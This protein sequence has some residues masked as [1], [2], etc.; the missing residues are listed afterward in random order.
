MI[1][2]P[3]QPFASANIVQEWRFEATHH[4][5]DPF[6][7]VDVDMLIENRHGE[8]WLVPA[9]WAGG[10]V[11]FVRFSAT[12]PGTY[13]YT[14]QCSQT[15][16]A[17][18]HDVKGEFEIGT[19]D[20]TNKVL[21]HGRLRVSEDKRY[22]QYGSGQPFFWLGDTGWMSL[23]KR[24]PFPKDYCRLIDDRAAKGFNVVQIV[25]GLYPDMD[26]G[27]DRGSNEAGLPYNLELTQINPAFYDLADQK[28]D[29]LAQ[30]GIVSCIVGAWGYF[31]M[32]MDVEKMKKHWR[33]L[34]A[35]W[36]AY[37]VVWCIAGEGKMAY[38]LSKTPEAD[39]AVQ[40]TG[41]TE[42]ARYV[43]AIDPMKRLVT[44]HATQK[45][46]DQVDDDSVIDFEMLQAGHSGHEV[47]P[48]M[49]GILQ[50][51]LAREPRMPVFNSETNYEGILGGCY[52]DVQRFCFW[53]CILTGA[54]GHTYGA[55]GIWQVNTSEQPYGPSPHGNNWGSRP[56]D[57]AMNLAGSANVALG[58]KILERYSWWQFEA[59][60]EWVSPGSSAENYYLP[61]AAGIPGKVRF[62]YMPRYQW[63]QEMSVV[64]IEPGTQYKA[65]YINPSSGQEYPQ[66]TI[67]PDENGAWLAPTQPELRDWLLILEAK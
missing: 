24:L 29:Y 38:Y 22:L 50:D 43:R 9:F 64:G 42:I 65:T 26:W 48:Y 19:Y 5:N 31:L 41:W 7:E 39:A 17:G 67:V 11:W 33:Y 34:I 52:D 6:N 62:I 55:N 36:G 18:L 14:T 56:W 61:Y 57:E 1:C 66:G 4:Y 28:I 59:H 15:A 58:K 12:L 2:Q 25:A 47:I 16:D 63:N 8:S 40:G 49:M 53:A 45:G 21:R 44:I 54:C 46:R 13:T 60:Q 23:T 20:G 27:D 30:S 35:R 10:G 51:E 32:W 37:P 3:A